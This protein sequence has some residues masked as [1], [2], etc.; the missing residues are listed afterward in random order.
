MLELF[1]TF[2]KETTAA[3]FGSPV[4]RVRQTFAAGVM[5]R[6]ADPHPII[7]LDERW[8]RAT[9]SV[10]AAIDRFGRIE[11]LQAAAANQIDAADYTLQHL[12]EALSV[13]MPIPADGS[14]LR[15]VLATV[16]E[17]EEAEARTLAA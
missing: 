4:E 11:T 16:A 8:A 2:A 9:S 1:W 10:T 17:R 12:L 3:L 5:A 13:A 6:Q 7:S 15:A 14:A